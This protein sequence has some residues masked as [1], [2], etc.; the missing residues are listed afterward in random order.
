MSQQKVAIVGAGPAGLQAAA[1]L[2]SLGVSI[3]IFERNGSPGGHL[4]QWHAL[5]PNFENATHVLNPLLNGVKGITMHLGSKV[6]EISHNGNTW[7][8]LSDDGLK[9]ESDAVLLTTGFNLFDA[10]R[11]EEYGYGVYPGVVTS[12]Q[13]EEMFNGQRPWPFDKSLAAPKIGFVHCVG[14]RDVKCGNRFC[15]KVCCVTAVKQAIEIRKRFSESAVTCFYMDLRMYGL[16]FEEL[17]HEA[18]VN[19][20]VQFIRGRLSEASPAASG[21]IQVKAEDTLMG[22]PLKLTLDM[23]VLMVGMEPAVK[24][25]AQNN[26]LALGKPGF[27]DG[28]MADRELNTPDYLQV[29]PGLFVAGACK[30]PA[31][32]PDTIQDA[33]AVSVDV[34]NFLKTKN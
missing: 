10:S 9:Y 16:G 12:A 31:S 25:T 34:Y 3:E 8:L 13:L 27:G 24:L 15:S 26:H 1:T 21:K 4:K 2:V 5:F 14:S 28:F 33:K 30:G 6:S 23:L 18:Q 29:T 19:H 17:Y 11:K 32:L 22:R 20:R 7:R